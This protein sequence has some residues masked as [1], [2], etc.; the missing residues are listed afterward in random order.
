MEEVEPLAV[1][2]TPERL[3][4]LASRGHLSA[5]AFERALQ[6]TGHLPNRDAWRDF[7]STGLL[8][9]SAVLTLCGVFFFFAYN[10]ADMH[11]FVKFGVIEIALVSAVLVAW[12]TKRAPLVGK[13]ALTAATLL[14][15]VLLA[16][17]GQVYQ[18]GAD[19]YQLFGGWALLVVGWVLLGQFGPLWLV[20]LALLNLTLQQYGMQATDWPVGVLEVALFALNVLA[21]LVWEVAQLRGVPWLSGRWAPRLIAIVAWFSIVVPTIQWIWDLGAWEDEQVLWLAPLLFLA[22][23]AITIWTYSRSIRDLFMLTICAFSIIIVSTTMIVRVV[24]ENSGGL[25]GWLIVSI[26]LVAQAGAA[27]VLLRRTALVWEGANA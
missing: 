20:W 3:Q 15:G 8:V 1:K 14:V 9:L 18:T 10:W 16:V 6:L 25:G 22:A 11:R 24:F 26:A 23:A 4:L 27:V 17:Y 13:L 2:A 19:A 12:R 5:A 7:F 21:L